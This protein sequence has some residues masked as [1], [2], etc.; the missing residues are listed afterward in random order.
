[1]IKIFIDADA[2]PVKEEV[3]K[4]AIRNKI[5]VI[6]TTIPEKLE[7]PISETL[8]YFHSCSCFIPPFPIFKTSQTLSKHLPTSFIQYGSHSSMHWP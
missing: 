8:I 1:M 2:C 3:Y 6:Q 4:V 7:N 5:E